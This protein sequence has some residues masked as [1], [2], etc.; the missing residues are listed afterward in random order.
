MFDFSAKEVLRLRREYHM[1]RCLEAIYK[2]REHIK[3]ERKH[4]LREYQR[5]NYAINHEKMLEK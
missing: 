5:R 4:R 2:G 3:Q 1:Q